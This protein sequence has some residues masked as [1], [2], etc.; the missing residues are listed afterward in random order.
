MPGPW[1]TFQAK[2]AR[3]WTRED[4]GPLGCWRWSHLHGAGQEARTISAPSGS[5]HGALSSDGG[6]EVAQRSIL[7]N[8][9]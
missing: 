6:E 5:P 8:S 7:V 1:Q 3:A 4:L 2:V 9:C